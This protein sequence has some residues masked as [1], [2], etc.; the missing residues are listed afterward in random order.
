MFG[1]V[2]G[3]A[4]ST[5]GGGGEGRVSEGLLFQEN[6]KFITLPP[7]K[8]IFLH[9]QCSEAQ[10]IE[11]ISQGWMLFFLIAV[12]SFLLTA[13]LVLCHLRALY[14]IVSGK[15]ST[16]LWVTVVFYAFT[17]SDSLQLLA[18]VPVLFCSLGL[19]WWA[20]P[21]SCVDKEESWEWHKRKE[22][23]LAV[24]QHCHSS[25]WED[26]SPVNCRFL[27]GTVLQYYMHMYNVAMHCNALDHLP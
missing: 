6:L 25:N 24:C 19:G 10:L 20:K 27:P 11:G 21:D 18:L 7:W 15:L 12:V 4:Q 22:Q 26:T 5:W 3:R 14:V 17:M 9:I 2:W 1:V 23:Q 16:R 8:L 13:S